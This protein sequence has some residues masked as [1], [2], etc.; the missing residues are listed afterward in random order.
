MSLDPLKIS[1]AIMVMVADQIFSAPCLEGMIGSGA[2]S[3]VSG[4]VSCGF[5][6]ALCMLGQNQGV[7]KPL[8]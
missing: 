3:L 7:E 1:S 6:I 8:D 4:L 5:G 2:K